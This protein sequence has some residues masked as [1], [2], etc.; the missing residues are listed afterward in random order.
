MLR[1]KKKS[2]QKNKS[3]HNLAYLPVASVRLFLGTVFSSMAAKG[4]MSERQLQ[5]LL[6]EGKFELTQKEDVK[7]GSKRKKG[8]GKSATTVPVTEDE[9]LP[10]ASE[11]RTSKA[12]T[13]RGKAKNDGKGKRK[14]DVVDDDD[15]DA[16]IT[17][18]T[19]PTPIIGRKIV[20][21]CF[22][23]IN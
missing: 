1:E 13:G 10:E 15:S 14:M 17:T 20:I 16:V 7:S 9:E 2:I 11:P 6:A 5:K 22:S 19:P 3:G 8:R 4:A 21:V 18:T 12:I 23:T